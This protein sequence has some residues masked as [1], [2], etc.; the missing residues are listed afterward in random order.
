MNVRHFNFA[1]AVALLGLLLWI[2]TSHSQDEKIKPTSNKKQVES[3]VASAAD[4]VKAH[5]KEDAFKEFSNPRGAFVKG[6]SYIFVIDYKGV[7]LANGG[8]P[9]IIGANKYDMQDPKGNYVFRDI[10]AKAKQGGG[11]VSYYWDNPVTKKLGCKSSYVMPMED[12]FVIGSGFYHDPNATG[13]CTV[14]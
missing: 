9:D 2:P 3:F 12:Q 8:N 1:T 5:G 7:T 10:I 14:E 4:Y 6:L 13:E 11:W